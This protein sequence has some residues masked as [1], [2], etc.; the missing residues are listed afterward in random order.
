MALV[1]AVHQDGSR[2][3]DDLSEACF[4]DWCSECIG[5]TCECHDD[6]PDEEREVWPE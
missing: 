3:M 2:V 1:L 6:D 4:Y 5:C